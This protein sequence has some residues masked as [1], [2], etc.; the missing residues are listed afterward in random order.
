MLHKNIA[1]IVSLKV[2]MLLK[3]IIIFF[4]SISHLAPETY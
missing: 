4:L 3:E 1:F 2:I